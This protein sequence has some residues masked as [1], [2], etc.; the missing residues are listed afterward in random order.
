MPAVN[1]HGSRQRREGHS[2]RY[3]LL[4]VLL[5][6]AAGAGA[7][8]ALTGQLTGFMRQQYASP[9]A[10]LEV[11]VKT[12]IAQRPVCGQPQFSLP[13][14][15]RIWG[16]ISVAVSCGTQ[17]RFIQAEIK[18]TDRYV[19]AAHPLSA[20]Q[21]LSEED[22][23]WRTGRLDLL[24]S[25]PLRDMAAVDGSISERALGSGQPLTAAMLRRPWLVKIGQL[26]QVAA[27]GDGFAVQS[28]GKAMSNAAVNDSLRVRMDSGQIVT[29][30]LMADGTVQV[31]L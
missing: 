20:N 29:G 12:P 10:T 22:V 4:A 8:D 25:V 18:V 23:A 5:S 11:V 26:V 31:V 24:P 28:A 13:S 7:A 9:T 17:K 30:R 3:G 27:H 15:N 21:T 6:V 19:V 16:N 14:S 1:R 2:W